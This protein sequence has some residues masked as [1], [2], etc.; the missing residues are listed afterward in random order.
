[1]LIATA[2]CNRFIDYYVPF[3]VLFVALAGEYCL[4]NYCHGIIKS[5]KKCHPELVSGSVVGYRQLQDKSK[6]VLAHDRFRNKFGM[7]AFIVFL[8]IVILLAIIS[9]NNFY[10]VSRMANN[11]AAETEKIK[12]AAEWLEKNTPANAIVFNA[13]WG[14]FPKLF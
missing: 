1:M 7:A 6:R 4:K 5:I 12:S 14:D 3:M 10:Q 2:M 11:S 9:I 8:L 13:N